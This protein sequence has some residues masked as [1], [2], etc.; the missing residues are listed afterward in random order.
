MSFDKIIETII[1]SSLEVV[2]LDEL[3]NLISL[4]NNFVIKIGFDPTTSDLHLGHLAIILKLRK[5]QDLGFRVNVIIGD[6]TAMIGDPSGKNAARPP[7]SRKKIISN[8]QNYHSQIYKFL[9]PDLTNIYFNS[10]W[11]NFFS[12]DNFIKLLSFSTV[13][14]ML[15]RNDFKNRFDSNSP[16]FINEFVYPLLQAYDSVFLDVDLEIGGMDQK[17]NFLIGRE[18]QKKF[19][20]KN[21]VCLMMPLLLGTDGKNKMSKSL[22]NCINLNDDAYDI[23][24]KVMSIPDFLIKDYLIYLDIL[25][26]KEYESF[27]LSFDNPMKLKSFLAYKIVCL[28]Y[29]ESSAE[30]SKNKFFDIFSKKIFPVDINITNLTFGCSTVYLYDVLSTLSVVSSKS[31]F[32]RF[33]SCRS[34][35]INDE[36]VVNKL[37]VFDFNVVYYL[38]F[39]KKQFFK[40][41]LK[42]N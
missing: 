22:H 2:S 20:Q 10:S 19:F 12:F 3:K 8:Y 31:D 1:S 14:R 11:Y 27:I 37:F 32:K 16:I 38:K 7:L 34:I 36:I 39:G 40:I 35:E 26:F 29:N 5:L 33:L 24:C 21:Q 23:F 30:L 6:F 9:L 15:E 42:K 41:F 28:I 4:K 17:F 18:V 25:D 13:S